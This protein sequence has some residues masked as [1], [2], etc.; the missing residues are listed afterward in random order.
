MY[1]DQCYSCGA[2]CSVGRP[3]PKSPETPTLRDQF[4]MAALTGF[5]ASGKLS[6]VY[7]QE[8]L[9]GASYQIADAMMRAR[10]AK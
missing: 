3:V 9:A 5:V 8:V 4:A 1:F 7:T 6:K 10:E 2:T